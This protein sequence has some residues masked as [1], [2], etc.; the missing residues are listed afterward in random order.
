MAQ[1]PRFMVDKPVVKRTRI[2]VD[3]VLRHWEESDHPDLFT[4]LPELTEGDVKACR[5]HRARART[6]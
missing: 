4:A 5:A 2:P 1:D 6:S 3:R